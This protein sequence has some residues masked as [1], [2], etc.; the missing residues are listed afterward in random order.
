MNGLD[1]IDPEKNEIHLESW[2]YTFENNNNWIYLPFREIGD[3]IEP[4]KCGSDK[5]AWNFLEFSTAYVNTNV[6][7]NL[8]ISIDVI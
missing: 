2:R 7:I 3:S 5:Y 1:I 4:Y 8:K 6:I